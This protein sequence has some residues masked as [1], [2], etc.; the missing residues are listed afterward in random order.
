MDHA[1]CCAFAASSGRS[2]HLIKC[3][4]RTKY[5]SSNCPN[6][7]RR[8]KSSIKK[9]ITVRRTVRSIFGELIFAHLRTGLRPKNKLSCSVLVLV[10]ST[11]LC[12]VLALPA[13][14]TETGVVQPA[15]LSHHTT[16][17]VLT[18][19]QKVAGGEVLVQ[20][21]HRKTCIHIG[22]M[23]RGHDIARLG[24]NAFPGLCVHYLCV[25]CCLC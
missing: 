19:L 13:G 16:R 9:R 10:L 4:L 1:V 24:I 21:V 20:A 7:V 18:R 14:R 8:T 6:H 22:T 12:A 17:P 3:Q 23:T 11:Y 2:L 25:P 15:S 5:S